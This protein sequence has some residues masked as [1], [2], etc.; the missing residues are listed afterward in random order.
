M[1][2]APRTGLH[3]THVMPASGPQH[4][5]APVVTTFPICCGP[6]ASVSRH[7]VTVFL[8]PCIAHR[9]KCPVPVG[10]LMGLSN[11]QAVRLASQGACTTISSTLSDR[12]THSDPFNP[13]AVPGLALPP[14]LSGLPSK[15]SPHNTSVYAVENWPDK[16]LLMQS[17]LAEE[18]A[19][20]DRINSS[21]PI[22]I[23]TDVFEGCAIFWAAGLAS[24][25]DH[26]FHGQK[27][28]TSLV[29][30]VSNLA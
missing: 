3:G 8:S 2:P 21:L 17:A 6:L 18:P 15:A 12:T 9:S 5:L 11:N 14:I 4:P 13:P 16:P 27:R 1:G 10:P 29:V 24:T 25:P 23:N 28:K 7:L 26:M 30:Q 22:P 19:R 20:V